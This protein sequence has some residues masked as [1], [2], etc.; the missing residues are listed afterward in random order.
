M[1]ITREKL[2]LI[3]RMIKIKEPKRSRV[4]FPTTRATFKN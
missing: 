4:H 2:W 3:G 1:Q